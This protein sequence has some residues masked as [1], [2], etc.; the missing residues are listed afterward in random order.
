[1][2]ALGSAVLAKT[3]DAQ[4]VRDKM[5][6]LADDKQAIDDMC[7]KRQ[8]DLQDAYDLAVGIQIFIL[9]QTSAL[10]TCLMMSIN[11]S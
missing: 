8:K 9:G 3:P 5:K 10:L 11:D 6:R 1:M 7:K 2:D 4:D